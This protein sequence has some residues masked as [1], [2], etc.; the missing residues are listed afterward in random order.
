MKSSTGLNRA[1]VEEV[2]DNCLCF[3]TQKAARELARR[4]DRIFASLGITNGQYSMMV[5]IAGMGQP[6]PVRLAH[7]LAMDPATVTAAVKKLVRYK[8]VALKLDKQ[9][10]RTRRVELTAAGHKVL[11]KALPLW[12][13][14]HATIEIA[15]PNGSPQQLRRGLRAVSTALRQD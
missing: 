15:L 10:K 14:E 12:R 2:R 11:A 3:A 13:S 7:F 8:F 6:K 4:F 5:A 9:D 1:A